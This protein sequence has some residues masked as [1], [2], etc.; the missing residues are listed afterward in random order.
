[1]KFVPVTGTKVLF[2]TTLT[3][4]QD[5]RAFVEATGYTGAERGPRVIDPGKIIGAGGNWSDPGFSQSEDCPVIDV[6]FDDAEAFC[7]WLSGKEHRHYRLPS[8]LEWSWAVG[9]GPEEEV[10][11]LPLDKRTVGALEKVYPWGTAWPPPPMVGNLRDE[12]GPLP[13]SGDH[14]KGWKDGYLYTSPVGRFPPNRFGLYDMVGNAQQ[15][16]EDLYGLDTDIRRAV[17]HVM[18][19]SSWNDGDA[20]RLRSAYRYP[21]DEY[22]KPWNAFRCVFDINPGPPPR[23]GHNLRMSPAHCARLTSA[24]PA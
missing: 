6:N 4:V 5:F 22:R 8:D 20:G 2:C 23:T 1:M 3:R 15:M 18:R 17:D 7:A 19:G 10:D 13:Q 9:I 12:Y 21:M 16:T 11:T 14:L 24:L